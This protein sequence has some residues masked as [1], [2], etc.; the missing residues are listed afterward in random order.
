[1]T[2]TSAIILSL[3]AARDALSDPW[4]GYRNDKNIILH[5]WLLDDRIHHSSSRDAVADVYHGAGDAKYNRCVL[6]H[7][8]AEWRVMLS[9]TGKVFRPLISIIS[10]WIANW[11]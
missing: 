2:T 7:A 11:L 3:D 8:Y 5:H 10:Y 1:M 6:I 4:H 9:Y